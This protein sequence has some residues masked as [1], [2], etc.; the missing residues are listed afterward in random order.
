MLS[1]GAFSRVM[2]YRP[3]RPTVQWWTSM[4]FSSNRRRLKNFVRSAVAVAWP[5]LNNAPL[6]LPH[7]LVQRSIGLQQHSIYRRFCQPSLSVEFFLCVVGKMSRKHRSEKEVRTLSRLT[8]ENTHLWL[9]SCRIR[10][11]S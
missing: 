5:C 2:N 11:K 10:R 7:R 1:P 3:K 4:S 8:V 9:C 6:P